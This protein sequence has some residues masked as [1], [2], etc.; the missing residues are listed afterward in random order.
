[1]TQMQVLPPEVVTVIVP[2]GKY[3]LG[4]PC[5]VVPKEDWDDL[6]ASCDYFNH[7]VGLVHG[8]QVLAF[9][10]RYGDGTYCCNRGHKYGVDA[11]IIG[12]V[13]FAYAE[14]HDPS[15]SQIVEF[16][17]N[18][19]CTRDAEGVL[20]FGGIEIDTSG[21]NPCNWDEEDDEE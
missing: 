2:P 3:V 15:L 13:P 17:Y 14:E 5:Y 4:D 10:T 8:F 12:L 11:G 18:V 7:P 19:K 1:M 6:L 16:Q 20:T 21:N 9:S